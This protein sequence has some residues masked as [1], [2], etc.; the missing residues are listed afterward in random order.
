VAAPILLPG[1]GLKQGSAAS[2]NP[3]FTLG[4]EYQVLRH[5]QFIGHGVEGALAVM[6]HVNLVVGALR[7]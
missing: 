6:F 4:L 5:R 1:F 2:G 7:S 3:K